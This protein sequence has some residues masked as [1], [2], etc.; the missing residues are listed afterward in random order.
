MCGLP[1]PGGT[2]TTEHHPSRS[3][4]DRE[5]MLHGPCW[6]RR[7]KFFGVR[8]LKSMSTS[9][10][11]VFTR[12]S[13]FLPFQLLV[14]FRRA[15]NPP[16]TG[17]PSEPCMCFFFSEAA[18]SKVSSFRTSPSSSTPGSPS[19]GRRTGPCEMRKAWHEG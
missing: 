11:Q 16:S 10:P 19:M 1:V 18:E 6:L 8:A 4:W 14:A 9:I 17:L 2:R 7:I 13:E 5:R 3:W 12:F 15:T